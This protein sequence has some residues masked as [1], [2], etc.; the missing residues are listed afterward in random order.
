MGAGAAWRIQVSG[1]T[2]E[3][4]IA[5]GGYRLRSRGLTQ[6]KGKGAMHT[7]WLL[8]KDGFDKY[9]PTPP[10]LESEEVLFE[11][12]AE[13]DL[14]SSESTAGNNARSVS[15][16]QSVERQRSDPS[17]SVDKFAWQ[18]SGAASAESSPPPPSLPRCR[19][20]RSS[21]STVAGLLDT[22]R[23]SDRWST[24]GARILRRQ[25]SL[26]RGDVLA[27]AAAEGPPAE[28]LP[29]PPEEPLALR[30]PPNRPPLARYRMRRDISMQDVSDR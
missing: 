27:A 2:A 26:E 19:Y 10:P 9:L 25:W 3:R 6:V 17:P 29:P 21:V 28:P 18:R 13:E 11:A 30:A 8:G 7:Y 23:L 15:A 4:L 5:A 14:D 12:E 24:S 22:P 16:T 20:L 1:A